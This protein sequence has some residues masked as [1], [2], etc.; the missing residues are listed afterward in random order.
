MHKKKCLFFIHLV[1]VLF[2]SYPLLSTSC[3]AYAAKRASYKFGVYGGSRTQGKEDV[4]KFL[5]DFNRKY[6]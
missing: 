5:I 2:L 1:D 6:L 3:W 4:G